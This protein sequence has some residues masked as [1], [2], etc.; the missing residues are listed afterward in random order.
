MHGRAL[1][2]HNAAIKRFPVT[3]LNEKC[4]FITGRVS[5]SFISNDEWEE[6]VHERKRSHLP[7]LEWT[8]R[9][10][11]HTRPGADSRGPSRNPAALPRGSRP[12]KRDRMS[13]KT[14]LC[15]HVGLSVCVCP[16]FAFTR[17]VQTHSSLLKDWRKIKLKCSKHSLALGLLNFSIVYMSYVQLSFLEILP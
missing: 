6:T 4:G 5:L 17:E 14:S 8:C 15:T 16:L 12:E 3:S 1:W 10:L 13:V 11:P 7:T 2:L 9:G